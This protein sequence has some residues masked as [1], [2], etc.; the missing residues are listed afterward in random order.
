MKYV[1]TSLALAATVI[2]GAVDNSRTCDQNQVVVCRGNG[3]G[4]FVSLG[5][6]LR[7]LLGQSCSTGNV[8]C[9]S[10]EDVEQV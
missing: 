10:Q 9:C 8:Y 1:F 7:G 5:N 3:N 4:G 2:A 6:I